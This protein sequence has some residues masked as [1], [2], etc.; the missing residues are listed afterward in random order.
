MKWTFAEELENCLQVGP[1]GWWLI[2]LLQKTMEISSCYCPLFPAPCHSFPLT[3]RHPK[4]FFKAK[5]CYIIRNGSK[6][7]TKQCVLQARNKI[8]AD[9]V[10][11]RPSLG[12]KKK[13]KIYGIRL[14]NFVRL[15][16][17]YKDKYSVHMYPFS[18]T[19]NLLSPS[20]FIKWAPLSSLKLMRMNCKMWHYYSG[21]IHSVCKPPKH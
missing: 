9:R 8:R 16:E 1:I 3:A 21:M 17:L 19:F 11:V 13:T 6:M 5:W 4:Y 14:V 10:A 2:L 20:G 15:N 7:V 18:S 12:S